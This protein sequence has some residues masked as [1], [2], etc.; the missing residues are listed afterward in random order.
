M[1]SR[2]SPVSRA[3]PVPRANPVLRVRWVVFGTLVW[4]LATVVVPIFGVRAQEP[5]TSSSKLSP[6]E[7]SSPKPAESAKEGSKEGSK[8]EL[9]RR[10]TEHRVALTSSKPGPMAYLADVVRHLSQLSRSWFSGRLGGLDPQLSAWMT[11]GTRAMVVV[12]SILLVVLVVRR[13]SHRPWRVPAAEPT[14]P[15]ESRPEELGLDSW[16]RQVEEALSRGDVAAAL[17]ALWWWWACRLQ[18]REVDPSWTTRELL[19]AVGRGDLRRLGRRFDYLAYGS[20]AVSA[21]EVGSLWHALQ[22]PS[23][24]DGS[25]LV[26]KPEPEHG[27]PER[28]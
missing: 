18:A 4:V 12:L 17:N 6:Q 21:E 13:F 15:L 14:T 27:G 5:G 20:E 24:A 3:N 26:V 28:V 8:E 1:V 7:F 11:Q 25:S 23:G 10:L 2:A 22:E 19:R 9:Q 16:R